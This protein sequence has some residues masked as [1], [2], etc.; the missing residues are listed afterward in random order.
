M[1]LILRAMNFG[2]LGSIVGHEITHS[3]GEAGTLTKI[4]KVPFRRHNEIK[5]KSIASYK[6]NT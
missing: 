1:I 4:F 5:E 2:A 3:F 6:Y